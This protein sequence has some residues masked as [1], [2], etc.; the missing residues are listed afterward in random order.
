MNDYFRKFFGRPFDS[1]KFNC[2]TFVEE[3]YKQF[4]YEFVHKFVMKETILEH[5]VE[6]YF[7]G[8][9]KVSKPIIGDLVLFKKMLNGVPQLYH[10][11]VMMSRTEYMHC[12]VRCG[13]CVTPVD[14]MKHV[15]EGF[16]RL[17]DGLILKDN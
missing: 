7:P 12:V 1:R 5:Q 9:T 16:Y 2:W 6:A 13:V 4:G 8:W 11:G 14:K 10:C 17:K 3:F 15:V